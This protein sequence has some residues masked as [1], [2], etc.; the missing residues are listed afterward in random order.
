MQKIRSYDPST[1]TVP[2][3]AEQ[4][5]LLN[6]DFKSTVSNTFKELKETWRKRK[7]G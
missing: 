2:E 7:S 3:E 5:D 4:L 6:K 1:E